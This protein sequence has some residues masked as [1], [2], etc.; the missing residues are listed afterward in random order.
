MADAKTLEE[1]A[2]PDYWDNRYQNSPDGATFEWF[3]SFESL[4][5][6]LPAHLPK[7]SENGQAPRILHLGCGNSTLPIALDTLGYKNQVCVDFSAVVIQDMATRFAEKDGIEWKVVDVRHMDDVKDG[8]FQVAIDKGT[9]DSMISG[10]LWDPPEIVKTNTRSYI[11]EVVRVLRPDGVF[12]YITY[13]QPHF[14]KPQL[15]R[16]GIWDLTVM[17]LNKDAGSFDYF[18][19]IMTKR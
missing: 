13:R 6:L 16:D 8:D 18:A 4:E 1:L 7:P 2:H 11:D 17:K 3:K 19:Y 9:L 5:P 10:S 12:I 14:V 15:I